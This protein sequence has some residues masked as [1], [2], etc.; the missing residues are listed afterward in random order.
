MSLKSTPRRYGTIAILIHWITAAAIAVMLGTGLS[1]S[2]A[3]DPAT[4][5]GLLRFHAIVGVCIAVLTVFRIVWWVFFDRR[6]EDGA[7][8]SRLEHLAA[9]SVH[10]GLYLV[11]LVMVASGMG[12]LITTG[13]NL[14]LFGGGG[15]LPDFALAPPFTVHAIVAR[16]LLI[17][18]LGHIAAALYHQFIRRDNLLARMG[19][20]R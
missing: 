15:A 1:A 2:N 10:Y 5:A 3:S 7:S 12:T 13:G 17:L 8:P 19:L 20:G 18:A 4:E 9:R 16:L 14:V 11:I 6:P